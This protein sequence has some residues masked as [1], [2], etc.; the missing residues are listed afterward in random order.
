M[1]TIA[2]QI[3]GFDKLKE[4]AN[5]YPGIAQKRVD[6]AIVRS[7]GEVDRNLQPITPIKTTSLW[8]SLH[9]GIRF[10]PFQGSIS[11]NIP[12]ASRVHDLYSPGTPFKNP[13]KNKNA[14]AGFLTVAANGASDRINS[15]FADA[16]EG[17]VDDLANI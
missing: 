6:T 11:S 2:I 13:S 4:L 14:V 1:S 16:I 15:S 7:I 12:Y 9:G 17:I 10:S 3:N 5:R 8:N